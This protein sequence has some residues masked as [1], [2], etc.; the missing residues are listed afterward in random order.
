MATG[1]KDVVLVTPQNK[2]QE[3]ANAISRCVSLGVLKKTVPIA[4]FEAH[5]VISLNPL[6]ISLPILST[7]ESFKLNG[8]Y[9]DKYTALVWCNG[10]GM[11]PQYLV[12]VCLSEREGDISCLRLFTNE[13]GP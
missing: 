1:D 4:K 8:V 7:M 5:N 12:F 13:N 2:C 6:K 10:E 3:W 9:P 11:S